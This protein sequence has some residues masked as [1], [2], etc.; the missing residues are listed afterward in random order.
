MGTKD[1]GFMMKFSLLSISLVLTS[2][3]AIS[4]ALPAM[5]SAFP[6][7]SRANVELLS[8]IPSFSVMVMVLASG[9]IAK[10]IGEKTTVVLGLAIAAVFGIV[11]FFTENFWVIM[12]SR[13]CLGIGFGLIN[14]LAVSLIG[15]FFSGDKKATLMGFRSSFE[16]LGQSLMTLVAG[17]LLVFSWKG[18]FLVY[19]IAV[20]ILVLFMVFVHKPHTQ[21][22]AEGEAPVTSAKQKINAPILLIAGFLFI[23][24]VAYIGIT[25]RFSSIVSTNGLGSMEQSSRI[26]SVMTFCGMLMGFVFGAINKV[27]K[28]YTLTVGI[29]LMAV[30]S[31]LVYSSQS[32]IVLSIGALL[33]GIAYPVMVA[34]TFNKISDVCAP[35]S[36]TLSTAVVL[37]GCNL[38]A[39]L[40]P[41]GLKLSS[42]IMGSDSLTVPFLLYAIVLLLI[43][44]GYTLFAVKSQ[45]QSA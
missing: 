6:E 16:S 37:V 43:A 10:K 42:A 19:L 38:G 20:P 15:E 2:A 4:P 5:V 30:G 21:P 40:A 8:T 45:K 22:V 13:I 14:S 17:F 25:V 7:Q 33:A 29:V 34:Y 36:S 31:I 1:R 35:D 11:P 3:Y 32:F 12:G 27:L 9:F 44:V 23:A 39:F 41:Y 28:Q 24:V 18:T 26:L